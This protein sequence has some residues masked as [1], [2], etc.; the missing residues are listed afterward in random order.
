MELQEIR[1]LVRG[2]AGLNANDQLVTDAVLD[3]FINRAVRVLAIRMDWDWLRKSSTIAT[4]A[5]TATVAL[6]IDCRK[7]DRIVDNETKRLVTPLDRRQAQRYVQRSGDSGPPVFCY[8]E[9]GEVVFVPTP[10]TARNYTVHYVSEET[11]LVNGTDEP[12]IPDYAIDAVVIRAAIM[13]A[14]RTDNAS[15]VQALQA[16]ERMIAAALED[17]SRRDRGATFVSSRR[18]YHI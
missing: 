15:L 10:T 4:V 9:G 11:N 3:G 18:D 7:V 16:E 8:V 1:P 2:A 6:P 13:C 12:K 5:D 17:E 14:T